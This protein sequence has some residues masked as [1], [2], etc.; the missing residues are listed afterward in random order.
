MDDSLISAVIVDDHKAV[1]DGVGMWCANADPPIRLLDAGIRPAAA[2]LEPGI[3]ADVVIFDLQLISGGPQEF[4]E[5][6]RLIDAGR[7]VVVYTQD[8]T[9]GTAVRCIDLG[10][11]G[12]VAK[13]EG[14]EHLI[15]A[16]RAAAQ[17]GLYTTPSLSG[18]IVTDD[19]PGRP[20]LSDKETDA[21]RAWFS[22]SSKTL[23]ARMLN[24]APTT[25]GTYIERARVKYAAAGRP[26][27]TKTALVQRAVEDGLVTW[28]EVESWNNTTS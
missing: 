2:W 12:F 6:T 26:A 3:H 25:I 11:A 16:I 8:F 9:R 23:A 14:E 5:L 27:T 20:R 13:S 1:R 15:D 24:I 19:D 17:D 10:A 7:R 18:S 21:L 4:G 28:S 22:S